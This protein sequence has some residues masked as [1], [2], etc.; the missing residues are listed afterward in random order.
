MFLFQSSYYESEYATFLSPTPA[1]PAAPAAPQTTL[2]LRPHDPPL[3]HAA[4]GAVLNVVVEEDEPE[5]GSCC[6]AEEEV[7]SS[8]A[9]T[10]ALCKQTET[11]AT[12]P[13]PRRPLPPPAAHS[14]GRSVSSQARQLPDIKSDPAMSRQNSAATT[15]RRPLPVVAD[16]Q[17]PPLPQP[18][19]HAQPALA[20]HASTSATSAACAVCCA[21]VSPDERVVRAAGHTL[22]VRCFRCRHCGMS[23]EHSQFYSGPSSNSSSSSPQFYCH[24]DYHELFSRRCA[25]C[26]TPIE[27]AAV[28]ALGRHWH[29]GHFFCGRCNR[30]FD[31]REAYCAVDPLSL[32]KSLAP[33]A[34]TL[35]TDSTEPEPAAED[36]DP[37]RLVPW[38][39]PCYAT[40][41]AVRCWKCGDTAPADREHVEALGRA[42]CARCFA[43][44]QCGAPFASGA[45][46]VLRADG[47]LA[48]EPC[49]A[50]RIRSDAWK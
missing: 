9:T 30:P 19:A 26:T 44:E 48:C 34:V 38:C 39:M 24:L 4:A 11:M 16:H 35:S 7:V 17:R 29:P 37:S 31:A 36:G 25:Y 43:C 12:A 47:T 10:A 6:V 23:L 49:E 13:P 46:F 40:R 3:K 21:P 42:W 15:R 1:E 20:R 28:G 14:G 41:T 5:G 32:A 2:T 8:A 27:G 45:E 33:R 22:H 50:R 18:P